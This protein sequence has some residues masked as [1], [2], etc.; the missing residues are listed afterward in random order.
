MGLS[1]ASVAP[2]FPPQVQSHAPTGKRDSALL[3]AFAM[4][5]LLDPPAPPE[6]PFDA[7][8]DAPF[9]SALSNRYLIYAMSTITARS[10]P[11]LRDGL[12]PVHRRLLWAMRLLKLDPA[13][14]YK[15][16]TYF[17]AGFK[18]KGIGYFKRYVKP[19]ALLLPI[20]IV[21]DFIKPLSLNFRL[22][23]NIL[24]DELTVTVLCSL[25]PILIPV[26]IMVLGLFA[27]SVQALI[28]ATLAAAYI[29]EVIE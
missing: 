1:A 9:D 3:S 23:G 29:G 17:S 28:F 24:A 4:S 18:I 8:V 27:S 14:A 7:I 15:K 16:L 5:D 25:V 13:S 19:T 20:N 11:D 22:F 10:L 6:D 26:P 2:F 21:E 12:K